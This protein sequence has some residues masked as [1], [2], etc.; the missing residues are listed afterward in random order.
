MFGRGGEEM[1]FLQ[2]K[3]I[4]VKIVPGKPVSECCFSPL[5]VSMKLNLMCSA[6]PFV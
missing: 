5:S 3:G 6:S 2:Q 4:Q 1:D